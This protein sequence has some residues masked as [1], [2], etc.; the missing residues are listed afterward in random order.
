MKNIKFAAV[1]KR[2]QAGFVLQELGIAVVFISVL[3]LGGY[4][5][6]KVLTSDNAID[7]ERDNITQYV[8][9]GF[10]A[11]D[12]LP[13]TS[14]VTTAM[15]ISNNVFKTGVSGTTVKNKFGGTTQ[16]APAS[17]AYGTND[18]LQYTNTGYTA[19][20]C[21]DVTR[22]INNLAYSIKVNTTDI[23]TGTTAFDSAALGT[24]CLPGGNNTMTF[25]AVRR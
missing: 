21:T 17:S 5:V 10:G 7:T 8:T 12:H 4:Q 13:D 9:R 16:V 3:G 22:K 15:F 19:D 11:I 14:T 6:Y 2:K 25:L 20:A 23:K 18:A 1:Q 24:A